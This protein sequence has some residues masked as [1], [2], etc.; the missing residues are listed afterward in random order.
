M[1]GRGSSDLIVGLRHANWIGMASA[2]RLLPHQLPDPSSQH[3]HH[4]MED[5]A[6]LPDVPPSLEKPMPLPIEL[7]LEVITGLL[8]PHDAILHSG[9]DITKT[10]LSFTLV[11]HETRKLAVRYLA[12]HCVHLDSPERLHSFVSDASRKRYMPS[13][14]A[15]SLAPF[16]DDIDDLPLCT[17]I[18]DL[19]SNTCHTLRK[20]VIDIPLRTCYP[21]DGHHAIR[22]VLREGFES[23]VNLEEFVSI[24]DELY[25]DLT[26]MENTYVW[27]RW[28][29]L[30]RMALYN[31]DAHETFWRQIAEHPSLETLV[32]SAPD[33][34]G[35]VDPKAAYFK[36]T[37][38][39]VWVLFCAVRRWPITQEDIP[40]VENWKKCDPEGNMTL[41]VHKFPEVPRG[42]ASD[43]GHHRVRDAAEDGTLWDWGGDEILQPAPSN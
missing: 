8:P 13:V 5:A 9:N 18:G 27:A 31:R 10:L 19:F 2:R 30:K 6:L 36:Y 33:S 17:H 4:A 41:L 32:L 26:E 16:G 3:Q 20:L 25:L 34:L 12:R 11:C 39:P 42:F 29:K 14:T 37:N 40:G 35:Y 1:A 22:S 7:V 38:R 43:S 15:C 28:P 21:E 23:L 24:Q